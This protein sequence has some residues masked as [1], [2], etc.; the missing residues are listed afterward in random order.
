M[1]R[2]WSLN[3]LCGGL[4]FIAPPHPYYPLPPRRF[5]CSLNLY[6]VNYEKNNNLS[7]HC[8]CWDCGVCA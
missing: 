2:K 4:A 8:A 7:R 3:G 5:N 6:E 1:T